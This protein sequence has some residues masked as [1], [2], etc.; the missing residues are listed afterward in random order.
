[1]STF[2]W[3][4][5]SEDGNSI[6]LKRLDVLAMFQFPS[7][8]TAEWIAANRDSIRMG[9]VLDVETTGLS[10]ETD[11]IIEIGIRQFQFNRETG[12]IL[13]LNAAYSAFQDPGVPIHEEITTLTGIT[14]EMVKGQKINWEEVEKILSA[15][16]LVI[17]HNASFDR[18]F[19]DAKSTISN[20]KIWACSLKQVDWHK[21]GLPSQ[22]LD[23]LSLYHGFF[24]DSHRALNDADSLLFLLSLRDQQLQS[25]YFFE[26]LN[27]ARKP[28]VMLHA[29]FAPFEVKDALRDRKYRWNP[30]QKVW[31]KRLAKEELPNETV[32]LTEEVYRGTFRGQVEEI[33]AKDQFKHRS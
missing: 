23:V 17:A 10:H 26:L 1:M 18:P 2:K 32:W 25:P 16:H 4:G 31:S 13:S 22:K 33:H 20:E 9:A 30:Q 5:K 24:N 21:K 6:T 27:E 3:V 11:Q 15:S 7:Y 19:I 29:N 8:A 14:D 12:E 28:M